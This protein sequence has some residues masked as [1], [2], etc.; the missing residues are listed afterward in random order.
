MSDQPDTTSPDSDQ[1]PVTYRE[2]AEGET[3]EP[4]ASEDT[5]PPEPEQGRIV[6]TTIQKGQESITVRYDAKAERLRRKFSE[7]NER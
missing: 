1:P 3:Y 5:N 4:P 6:V 2:P 7:L